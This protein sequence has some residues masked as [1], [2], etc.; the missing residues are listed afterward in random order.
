MRLRDLDFTRVIQ[1]IDKGITDWFA[2]ADLEEAYEL[3]SWH[4][5]MG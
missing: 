4:P 5:G 3:W 1:K 2:M